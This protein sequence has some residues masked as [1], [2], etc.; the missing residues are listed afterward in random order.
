SM[1]IAGGCALIL[2]SFV[3]PASLKALRRRLAERPRPG[4]LRRCA[5]WGLAEFEEFTRGL[6]LFLHGRNLKHLL[7]AI[8]LTVLCILS[9]FGMSATLL[10]GLGVHPDALRA[11]GLNL[12]LT[13]VLLFVPT[14]GASGVAEA[15]AAGLYSMICPRYMLGVYVVLWRLFSFYGGAI[16]GGI[17]ALRHIGRR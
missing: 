13:S 17:L 10:A 4:F 5:L 1:I 2:A 15:G 14:P 3:F 6:S 16:T 11:I 8:G 7:L 12:L 9:L